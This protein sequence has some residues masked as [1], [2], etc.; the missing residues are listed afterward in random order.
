MRFPLLIAA[1]V[2]LASRPAGAN[3][4]PLPGVLA[5]GGLQLGYGSNALGPLAGARLAASMGPVAYHRVSLS[6]ALR[7]MWSFGRDISFPDPAGRTLNYSA[8]FY[9]GELGLEFDIRPLVAR[10][11]LW[12]G[13]GT[14]TDAVECYDESSAC[15]SSRTSSGL[16]LFAPGFFVGFQLAAIAR[17]LRLGV[18]VA[19][20]FTSSPTSSRLA[21]EN[22]DGPTVS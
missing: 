19:R 9:G 17:E 11:H 13:G 8:A 22:R 16:V 4:T 2:G 7:G 5:G 12:F 14:V 6:L 20:M 21:G 1:V 15:A 18:E 10:M 3:Q